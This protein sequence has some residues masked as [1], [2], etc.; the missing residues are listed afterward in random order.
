MPPRPDATG[1]P[2]NYRGWIAAYALFADAEVAKNHVQ[3]ILDIDPAG[4][5]AER[6][7][8]EAQLLGQ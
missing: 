8:G 4:E 7:G 6:A 5:A 3:D 1:I 2:E